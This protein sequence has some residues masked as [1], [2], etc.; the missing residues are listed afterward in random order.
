MPLLVH[1]VLAAQAAER[2]TRPALSE[3]AGVEVELVPDG[4]LAAVVSETDADEVLPSRANLTAHARVLE[5]LVEQATVA[6][7]RFGV[8]VADRA[9]LRAHVEE[10][11]DAYLDVLRRLQGHLELRLRGRY[12]QDEVVR[13]VVAG[14]RRAARLRGRAELDARM[15]LGERIVAGIEA[16]RDTDRAHVLRRLGPHLADVAVAEVSEPLDA[17][18]LSLLVAR[19]AMEAFDEALESLGAELLPT[20]HMELVGPVPPFSFAA[21]EA[22]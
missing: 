13:E 19:T 12:E 17:F 2:L 14:D 10:Q 22:S 15:E 7:M 21:V 5:C 4:R 20:V 3:A 18:A 11:Q 6:P 16:R 9:R 1:G 8:V